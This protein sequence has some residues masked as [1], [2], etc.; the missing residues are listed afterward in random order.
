MIALGLVY[1][2][3]TLLADFISAAL[4]A[5]T[6]L[7]EMAFLRVARDGLGLALAAVGV[8]NPRLPRAVRW[9]GL[10]YL[11]L[12][13]VYFVAGAADS[14]RPLLLVVS[15]AQL[16]IPVVLTLVGAGS[17]SSPS[18]VR[19]ASALT[20]FLGVASAL[21]GMWDSRNTDFWTNV[22]AYGDY[23]YEV[24]R[25]QVGYH[26]IT[27]LPWNFFGFE[28]VRRAAGLVAAP[29]AQG[30]FLSI[31]GVVAFA[32]RRERAPVTAYLLLGLAAFG[33]Y[34]SG[35]RGAILTLV[36]ALPLVVVLAR[37]RSANARGAGVGLDI[38]LLT[39][40][41]AFSFQTLAFIFSYTVGLEDGSTIG[42]VRAL[43]RNLRDLP[44]VLFL[45]E[46]LSAAGAAAA[47]AGLD[48]AGGGE[49]SIFSIAFQIG[50]PGA[51][52]FLA[53]CAAIS[54]GLNQVRRSGGEFINLAA[55]LI[56]LLISSAI[57]LASSETLLS[58]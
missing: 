3:L 31:V 8:F 38:V 44:G 29:L 25:I 39:I 56:A 22:I 42:H 30:A 21:F 15:A 48:I 18:G 7:P 27:L 19:M 26:P 57:H 55:A 2:A 46:G 58:V 52:V 53:F 54:R 45:G 51:I 33:I 32:W 14:Q 5:A 28:G 35:T 17:L 37:V 24:K 16:S 43:Q 1:L 9:T 50:V 10:G 34:Q 47:D 12:I 20:I 40:G 13:G 36:L 6:D 49:G 41:L 23:L 11:G 4:Y